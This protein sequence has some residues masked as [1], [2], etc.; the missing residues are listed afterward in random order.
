[1]QKNYYDKK[2]NFHTNYKEGDKVLIWKPISQNIVD[3]RKFK[4]AFSGPWE[5]VKVLSPWNFLLKHE[6][7]GKEEVVHFNKMRYISPSVTERQEKL[8]SSI[9]KS[10]D[11][12]FRSKS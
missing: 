8:D 11:N 12:L 7:T 2:M 9:K 10:S 1:M 5:I 6:D 3:Y 4:E